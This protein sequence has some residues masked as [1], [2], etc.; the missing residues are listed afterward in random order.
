[1]RH[2]LIDASPQL[3]ATSVASP[4]APLIDPLSRRISYLRLS[5]TDRCDLRC[6]YCMPERMSFLPR[7]DLL[8]FD[9]LTSLV[10]AF[11]ARGVTKLRVTGGEP[12]VRRDALSLLRRFGQR[13]SPHGGLSELTLTTNGTQLADHAQELADLGVRRINVSL[14]T[15]KPDIYSQLTRRDAFR[16]VMRGIDAADDAGLHIK[17]NTVA[18]A[19]V[20]EAEI[21]SLVSWAHARGFDIS[22]IEVMPL[23]DG[24]AGRT[25]SFVSLEAVRQKLEAGWTLKSLPD[26][27]GG[28]S[29]YVRGV[30][31]GGRL[32]F[33]SPLSHNFCASCN[34][35]RVTCTG[36]LYACLG[37]ED[38]A[39]L[40][41]ALRQDKS[42]ERLNAI[43]DQVVA[44]KPDGHAFDVAT[45]NTPSSPRTMSVT[46]G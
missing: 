41:E 11:I 7:S 39:D 4:K 44:A 15:L 27:T 24:V 42:G 35:L 45:L 26:T 37:H 14:D 23:G 2:T 34:R 25:E 40:R 38:G 28:P 5:I 3:S 17:I 36:R 43:L 12:L 31:T 21:P 1:M 16:Q 18:L 13:L 33:I 19:D 10:D 30:E 9:E 8:N 32:G 29:R 20:N 46:G 6:A 22:L